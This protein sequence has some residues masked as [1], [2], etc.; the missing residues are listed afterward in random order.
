MGAGASLPLCS[1]SKPWGEGGL[2][3]CNGRLGRRE[4]A[5]MKSLGE[6]LGA[7]LVLL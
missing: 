2:S 7:L 6:E 1:K 5:P 4:V 3:M